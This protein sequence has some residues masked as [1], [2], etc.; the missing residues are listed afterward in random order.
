MSQPLTNMLGHRIGARGARTRRALLDALRELLETRHLGEIRVAD[1]A[2][3]AGLSPTNF[4]TYFR[5][6]DDAV[7][8]LCEAPAEEC[9]GL[10]AHLDADWSSE[11]AFATARALTLDLLA[12]WDRHGPVLR[13]EHGLADRGDAPFA[14]SRIRRLRRLHLALER[15]IAQAQAQGYHPA[16]LSPRL[17]SYEVVAL[18]ESVARGFQL[19]RRADTPEAILDTTAHIVARLVTGR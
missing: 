5:T 6:P 4:Y 3:L 10:A 16:G 15:R 8:V 13:L 12:I 7:L 11:R 1:I 17:T 2:A 9:M 18:I 14:E 19:L